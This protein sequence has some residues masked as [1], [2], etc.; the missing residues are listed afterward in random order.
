[1]RSYFAV[2]FVLAPGCG[3]GTTAKSALSQRSVFAATVDAA[4]GTTPQHPAVARLPVITVLRGGASTLVIRGDV[5]P[6]RAKQIAR[7]AAHT[8]G[9]FNRRFGVTSANSNKRRAVD[10]CVFDGA[11]KYQRAARAVFERDPFFAIGFYMPSHRLVMVDT[12]RGLGNLRHEMIHPM[13]RD[14]WSEVPAWLDEGLASL[15]GSARYRRGRFRFLVNYRVRHFRR[16]RARGSLPGLAD[17]ANSTYSDVHGPEERAFYAVARYLL[18]NLERRGLL[19]RF[20]S[21]MRA[22]SPTPT[23]QYA[24]LKSFIDYR[25]FVRWTTRLR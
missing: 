1:M 23:Q 10:I 24:L 21:K 7:S 22:R 5:S 6:S 25:R 14:W 9:D 15:Y 13:V 4:D 11:T 17:L 2:L 16:A 8:Y 12:S 19:R 18:L 3:A 20:F